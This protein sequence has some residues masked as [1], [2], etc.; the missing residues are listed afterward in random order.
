MLWGNVIGIG[1]TALQYFT[2]IVSLD[3]TT[4]YVNT[5]PVEFDMPLIATI[6]IA[7]LIVCVVALIAPSHLVSFIHPAKSMRYE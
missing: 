7:T 3:P 5:V 2:S 4:Y 6:N 1:L